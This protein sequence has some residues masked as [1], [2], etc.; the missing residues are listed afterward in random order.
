RSTLFPYTTLFRSVERHSLRFPNPAAR[1]G[2]RIHGRV[3]PGRGYRR[4][5]GHL[6]GSERRV[7][8][9]AAVPRSGAAVYDP[10]GDPQARAPVSEPAGPLQPLL[11]MEKALLGAGI[12]CHHGNLRAESD[13]GGRA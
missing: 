8:A 2:I 1:A 4:Q 9:P 12:D 5:Y 11:R 6:F 3:E 7:A 10:R 13:G